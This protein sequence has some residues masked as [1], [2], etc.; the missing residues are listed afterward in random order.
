[1]NCSVNGDSCFSEAQF[2]GCG[3]PET[4]GSWDEDDEENSGKTGG[5]LVQKAENHGK[6]QAKHGKTMGKTWETRGKT[7]GNPWET[8]VRWDFSKSC[9]QRKMG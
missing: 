9:L 8:T 3:R 6:R 1:M 7:L 2:E 4:A 5:K